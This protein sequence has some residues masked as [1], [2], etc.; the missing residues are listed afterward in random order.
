MEDPKVSARTRESSGGAGPLAG[1]CAPAPFPATAQHSRPPQ[2]PA[3]TAPPVRPARPQPSGPRLADRDGLHLPACRP[4]PGPKRRS[5]AGF[6]FLLP[7]RAPSQVPARIPAPHRRLLALPAG[8]SRGN[9]RGG[10]GSRGGG[11]GPP[12][13]PAKR[14]L[15]AGAT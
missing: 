15:P 7:T 2:P 8:G 13:Q 9:R 3:D 4:H 14:Y 12:P 5:P 6:T 10:D 11:F 1:F